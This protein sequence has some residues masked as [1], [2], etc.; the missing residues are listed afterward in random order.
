MHNAHDTFKLGLQTREV[1]EVVKTVL[2]SGGNSTNVKHLL[3]NDGSPLPNNRMLYNHISHL[4]RKEGKLGPT[5]ESD[6]RDFCNSLPPIEDADDDQ[7]VC[8]LQMPEFQRNENEGKFQFSALFTT[9]NMI[10][11]FLAEDCISVIF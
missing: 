4:K 2:T 8:V 3:T 7:L 5:L 11:K 1:R 10:R 9:P 6:I